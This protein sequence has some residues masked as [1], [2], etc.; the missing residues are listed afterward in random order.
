M[1]GIENDANV[2]VETSNGI[3]KISEKE[4]PFSSESKNKVSAF[5]SKR[6]G[7]DENPTKRVKS[8]PIGSIPTDLPLRAPSPVILS[9]TKVKEIQERKLESLQ[10]MEAKRLARICNLEYETITDSWL[11]AL[12]REFSKPYFVRLKEFL[13]GEW[14]RSVKIFPQAEKI[15]SWTSYCSI[16]Q[17]NYTLYLGSV[18]LN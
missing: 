17:V 11:E 14:D 3:I 7:T 9:P 6:Q 16:D 1:I 2:A 12:E 4:P 5:F 18:C 13:Q 15:Y 10:R 8:V